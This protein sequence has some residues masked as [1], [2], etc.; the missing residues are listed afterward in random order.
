MATKSFIKTIGSKGLLSDYNTAGKKLQ[1]EL[2]FDTTPTAGS[3]N[4]V[5]SDGIKTA[6]NDKFDKYG[7]FGKTD[8]K[9]IGAALS[10]DGETEV[11]YWKLCSFT[12]AKFWSLNFV[13]DVTNAH[14][15]S[16]VFERKIIAIYGFNPGVVSSAT[17]I[18]E[19][20]NKLYSTRGYGNIIYYE[21]S[22][23]NVTIY[24]KAKFAPNA[25]QY[26]R[27]VSV[28]SECSISN[29]TWY[30]ETTAGTQPENPVKFSLGYKTVKPAGSTSV[31][32]YIGSDGNPTAC[33]DDFVHNGDVTSTYS[34]TGTAPVN[35]TAVAAAIN[36]LDVSS[37]GGDGKYISAISETDGKIS[38]TVTTMDATPTENSTKAVT[39]GGIKTALNNYVTI[40][41]IDSSKFH[42]KNNEYYSFICRT[43]ISNWEKIQA[44]F[45]CPSSDSSTVGKF[46]IFATLST[47]DTS[48]HTPERVAEFGGV[49]WDYNYKGYNTIK[50]KIYVAKSGDYFYFYAKRN[51]SNDKSITAF[52]S[53]LLYSTTSSLTDNK[54][55]D[56]DDATWQ[57]LS[58]VE[59][60]HVYTSTTQEILDKHANNNIVHLT[61]EEH[62]L[63]NTILTPPASGTAVLKSVNGVL[64]WVTE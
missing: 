54:S 34:S 39:S 12:T 7:F 45:F 27:L 36:A 24:I 40:T 55:A 38:A 41:K 42:V 61:S 20:N 64:Q 15:D 21:T 31:P 57:T 32:V 26:C 33:T 22:G 58:L 63:L 9:W 3:T 49:V 47:T 5:T 59:M 60:T 62:N 25:S 51:S 4:P 50:Y 48:L 28:L 23:N 52:R 19:G 8:G 35:G 2:I 44:D 30:Q 13:A 16:N 37:V 14:Y 6:L 56:L 18:R 46:N 10:V 1:T 53:C 29:L 17:E 11:K 43:N